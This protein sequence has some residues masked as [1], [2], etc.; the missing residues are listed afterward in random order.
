LGDEWKIWQI[1]INLVGNAIKFTDKGS[2]EISCKKDGNNLLFS[3]KDTWVWVPKDEQES[4]FEAFEQAHNDQTK[5]M[6]WWTWLWLSISK[7][8]VEMMWG[9]MWLESQ[10]WEW[11]TFYFTLPIQK[12]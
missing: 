1:I 7:N 9:E 8:F 11:T 10:E 2:V 4:I 5:I 3:V 6:Y 12:S